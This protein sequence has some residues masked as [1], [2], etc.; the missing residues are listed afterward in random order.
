M[1]KSALRWCVAVVPGLLP[2]AQAGAD[3]A[4]V[5]FL[6]ANIDASVKP[7]DDFFQYANGTWLKRNP[8]PPTDPAWGIDS[9][10]RDQLYSTLRDLNAR[11]A[12]TAA[13]AG[14]DDQKIGGFLADRDRR[15]PRA[16]ARSCSAGARTRAHRRG[17]N[18]APGTRCGVRIASAGRRCTVHVPGRPG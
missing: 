1:L 10:V 9:L 6:T 13:P 3:T 17:E 4:P 14:S 11:A 5:D 15:R 18:A 2:V 16:A 12:E 7:G 8:I